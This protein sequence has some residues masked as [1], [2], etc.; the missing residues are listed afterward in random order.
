MANEAQAKRFFAAMENYTATPD[1]PNENDALYMNEN[2][3]LYHFWLDTEFRDSIYYLPECKAYVVA[4]VEEDKLKLYQIIGKEKFHL[5]ERE[6][7]AAA[8]WEEKQ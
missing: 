7:V 2:I 4:A 3:C 6:E 1:V 5:D 8:L